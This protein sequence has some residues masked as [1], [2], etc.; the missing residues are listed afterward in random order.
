MLNFLKYDPE[1]GK[2]VSKGFMQPE[3]IDQLIDAGE[4]YIKYS[5][6]DID[7]NNYKYDASTG[8]LV[9]VDPVPPPAPELPTV[10]SFISFMNLF[11]KDEQLAIS[12]SDDDQ[13]KLFRLMATGAGIIDM[14]SQ[15]TSDGVNYMATIGIIK[16]SRVAEILS[17]TPPQ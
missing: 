16:K 1:T 14:G 7:V 8:Q 11:T 4:P 5:G 17:M 13:F 2:I 10:L 12:S 9:E 15:Y 6:Q 3:L